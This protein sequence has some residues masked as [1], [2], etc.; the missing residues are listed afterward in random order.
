MLP[1][2]AG[3]AV[4]TYTGNQM[5]ANNILLAKVNAFL[6][7]FFVLI[8]G[9]IGIVIIEVFQLTIVYFFKNQIINSYT[10]D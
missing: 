6:G 5:G 9:L 10:N 3:V 8:L 1:A 7:K 2:G 4:A